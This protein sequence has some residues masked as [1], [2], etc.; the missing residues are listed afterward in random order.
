[1]VAATP[2]K[3]L[4]KRLQIAIQNFGSEETKGTKR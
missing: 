1:M 4:P 3:D 2:F